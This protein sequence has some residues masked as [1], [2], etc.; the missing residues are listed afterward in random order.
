[1]PTGSAW[2][3][4]V[5]G[6]RRVARVLLVVLIAAAIAV[7]VFLFRQWDNVKSIYGAKTNSTEEIVRRAELSKKMQVTVLEKEQIYIVPPSLDQVDD[8]IDGKTTSD[9][10]K[11]EIGVG[12][13]PVRS[14]S[15]QSPG[16]LTEK[17][18]EEM[19]KQRLE[20]SVKE[21]YAYEVDLMASLGEL[22]QEA[23]DE[24]RA[25]PQERHTQDSKIKIGYKLLNKCYD[26]EEE[27][28]RRV[29]EIID[30]LRDDLK[31]LGAEADVADTLW[32]HYCDEKATAKEYYLSKYL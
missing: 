26:L 2:R 29:K 23:I 3:K 10:V 22:K 14:T 8:L 15:V 25:L 5:C 18:R 21:L 17:Q 24:Y 11:T 32:Q 1:M 13:E 7:S 9:Q 20:E 16:A 31:A 30:A 19:A 28:D 27:S 6:I 4:E 12:V